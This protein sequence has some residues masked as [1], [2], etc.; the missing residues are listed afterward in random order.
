MQEPAG[1]D[2]SE[3]R[4]ADAAGADGSEPRS[5]TKQETN[6]DSSTTKHEEEERVEPVTQESCGLGSCMMS[7]LIVETEEL[8]PIDATKKGAPEWAD[9]CDAA[10]DSDE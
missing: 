7:Q 10:E 8:T 6:E 9:L 4:P 5:A 1:P 2:G 3:P